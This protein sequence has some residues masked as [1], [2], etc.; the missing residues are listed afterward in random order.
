MV[1]NQDRNGNLFWVIDL[2]EGPA[3]A[4]DANGTLQYT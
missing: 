1:F 2:D 3:A 4:A